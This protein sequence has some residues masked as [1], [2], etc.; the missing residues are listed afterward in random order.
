MAETIPRWGMP[1]VNFVET[2]PE[3]IESSIITGYE[4]V[5]G[6]T[7]AAGDPIRLF[8]LSV[9]AEVIQLRHDINFAAQQNLLTY[10][11]G[12]YLDA[13]GSS[14]QV[15]RMPASYAETTLQ[16]TISQAL[17]QA[18]VIPAGFAVAA[19]NVTF[20]TDEELVIAS[21]ERT[22]TVH[23]SCTESGTVGN[24]FVAGQITNIVT[25]MP[26]LESATNTSTSVGGGDV[27]D[28]ASYAERIK[29]RPDSFSVAGPDKAY[30]FYAQSY[31]S[32]IIDVVVDS[33][34]PGQ[35]DVYPLL[36]GG[37]L[38]T[39][40]FLEGLLGYLSGETIRPLTDYVQTKS[41]T[42]VNY[43]IQVDYWINQSDANRV[44]AIQTAVKEAVEAYRLWQQTRIG[45]DI[46]QDEL[47]HKVIEAGA[48]RIDRTTLK[49]AQFQ[50][51]T[52]NQVAQCTD[53]VINFKGYKDD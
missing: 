16:F 6:R 42:A 50:E 1:Q 48:A 47:I 12:E 46:S 24:G 7:L 39:S 20:E 30:Q 44:D 40:G 53:V 9:A 32:S 52:T 33:P 22:G 25:P 18:Y 10:A 36:D 49:P 37:V 45:R 14:L 38:P 28:D 21:G 13:F 19:G 23:A 17:S 51:L 2:D 41:P 15:T 35:V 34:T 3:Q 26:Y 29:L 8:L 43:E 27:E 11:Q 4:R 31:S 5:A